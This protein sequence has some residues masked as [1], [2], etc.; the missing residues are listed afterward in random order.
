MERLVQTDMV[1]QTF[2]RRRPTPSEPGSSD[3]V[4]PAKS[5]SPAYFQAAD[6]IDQRGGQQQDDEE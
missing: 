5:F 1:S 3:G 2:Y 4:G 6:I